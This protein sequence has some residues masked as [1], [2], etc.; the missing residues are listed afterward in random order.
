MKTVFLFAVLL[1]VLGVVGAF[2]AYFILAPTTTPS[3]GVASTTS[4]PTTTSASSGGLRV[5]DVVS[6]GFVVVEGGEVCWRIEVFGEVDLRNVTTVNG[7][8]GFWFGHVSVTHPKGKE[9]LLFEPGDYVNVFTTFTHLAG[10]KILDACVYNWTREEEI[11][12][13]GTYEVVV[14]LHHS[15]ETR[16]TLFKKTFNYRVSLEANV[17]PTTWSRWNETL[18]I[19]IKNTGDLPIYVGNG[20]IYLANNPDTLIGWWGGRGYD[21]VLPGQTKQLNEPVTI[22]PDY[23]EYLKGKTATIKIT[24][25]TTNVTI[26]VSF[27]P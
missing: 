19:S 20:D 10:S 23:T 1:I 18:K 15:L 11:W 8:T 7:V 27:P 16:A 5:D 25:L 6:E 12:P 13:E 3:S 22:K 4:A 24:I 14:W 17:T 26:N 2:T 9:V 21:A